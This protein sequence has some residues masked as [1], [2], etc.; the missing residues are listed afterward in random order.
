MFLSC[1]CSS[2]FNLYKRSVECRLWSSFDFLQI[3]FEAFE[4]GAPNPGRDV[5]HTPS[6]SEVNGDPTTSNLFNVLGK[7]DDTD[8]STAPNIVLCV[9]L[10]RFKDL[11]YKPSGSI[12]WEENYSIRGEDPRRWAM[13]LGEGSLERYVL[14]AQICRYV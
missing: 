14:C 5:S 7:T 9:V 4:S 13:K 1:S 12:L 3:V 6:R 8:P 11:S 10:I 2:P